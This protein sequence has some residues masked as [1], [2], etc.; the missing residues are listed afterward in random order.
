MSRGRFAGS[1]LRH[2]LDRPTL[3]TE[4][5]WKIIMVMKWLSLPTWSTCHAYSRWLMVE[6]SSLHHGL[7]VPAFGPRK[8]CCQLESHCYVLH[9]ILSTPSLACGSLSIFLSYFLALWPYRLRGKWGAYIISS[10]LFLLAVLSYHRSYHFGRI[11]ILF[12]YL[13]PVIKVLSEERQ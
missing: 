4:V 13:F 9:S 6:I 12:S 10:N 2:S 5:R 1:R 11:I 3:W 7:G 8:G